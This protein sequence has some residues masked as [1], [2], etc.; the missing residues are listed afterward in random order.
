MYV[1]SAEKDLCKHAINANFLLPHLSSYPVFFSGLLTTPLGPLLPQL[2][3]LP[4]TGSFLSLFSL[5]VPGNLASTCLH[6]L[7][8][9]IRQVLRQ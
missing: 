7:Q 1:H 9:V 3:V 4:L 2:S 5:S 6:S 8:A